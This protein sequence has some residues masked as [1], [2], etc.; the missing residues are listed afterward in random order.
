MPNLLKDVEGGVLSKVISNLAASE[1]KT[2][3]LG[4]ILAGIV[5]SH[6]SYA[7]LLSGDSDA[8]ST[9]VAAVVVAAIGYFTNSSKPVH[10]KVG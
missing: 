6:T 4:A 10:T 3:I 1:P 5:A 2:T 9:V 7:K 8:I